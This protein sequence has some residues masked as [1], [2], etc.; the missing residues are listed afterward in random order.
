MLFL[1]DLLLLPERLRGLAKC[2]RPRKTDVVEEVLLFDQFGEGRPL[3]A[4]LSPDSHYA[5]RCERLP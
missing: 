4:A 1:P 2:L 3:V 5:P